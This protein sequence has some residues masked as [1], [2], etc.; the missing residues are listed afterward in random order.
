[1]HD[2]F[3]FDPSN[4]FK[5]DYNES[6][7]NSKKA[8]MTEIFL[9]NPNEKLQYF[10]NKIKAIS[11]FSNQFFKHQAYNKLINRYLKKLA[12][13]GDEYESNSF[14]QLYID[15]LIRLEVDDYTIDKEIE[16]YRQIYN[17]KKIIIQK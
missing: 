16:N 17:I 1:M 3:D 2:I 8:D 6:V 10:K 15:L 7:F 5:N 4:T 9:Q 13:L 12:F 11:K 14:K